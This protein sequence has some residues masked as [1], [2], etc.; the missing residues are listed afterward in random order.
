MCKAAI[1]AGAIGKN[2]GEVAIVLGHG[3]LSYWGS[4]RN[5]IP[6]EAKKRRSSSGFRGKG[7]DFVDLKELAG[8]SGISGFSDFSIAVHACVK[9]SDSG[10]IVLEHN[11][12]PHTI[13]TGTAP[14]IDGRIRADRVRL[15]HKG[16]CDAPSSSRPSAPLTVWPQN[17]IV[18]GRAAAADTDYFVGAISSLQIFNYVLSPEQV[19]FLSTQAPEVSAASD[20]TP[21]GERRTLDGRV[22]FSACSPEEPFLEEEHTLAHPTNPSI[23]LACTDNGWLPE[24]NGLTDARFLI[25]CPADCHKAKAPLKGSKVYSPAS[26]VC[27]AALHAG[28]LDL[29]GGDAVLVVHNGI[30]NYVSSKGKHGLVSDAEVEPQMRSFSVIHASPYKRLSCFSD[31]AFILHMKVDELALV[32]CPPGTK[33]S[34]SSCERLSD[35]FSPLSSVCRA[36]LHAGALSADGGQVEV[37]A[38]PTHDQFVGS[39][40]NGVLSL[41]SGSYLRSFSFRMPHKPS[42]EL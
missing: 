12:D 22:C 23:N 4:T 29:Q 40:K 6:S 31:G 32:S 33:H 25:T 24:F 2:G 15:Q 18:L 3:Q 16:K 9:V 1:H 10:E 17:N 20:I 21:G 19:K 14:G 26:S 41:K 28:V 5:G 11:C 7:G 34:V 13:S 37:K 8:S 39:E 38:G 36:A 42:E 30:N 27:K 35:I